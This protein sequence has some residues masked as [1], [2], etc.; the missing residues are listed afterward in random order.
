MGQRATTCRT[1]EEP[2][3]AAKRMVVALCVL[4]VL[5]ATAPV[6]ASIIQQGTK[7]VGTG[8]IGAAEQGY[9]VAVS[10]D[11]NTAV[12]GGRNDNGNV[13]AMWV[14][15]RSGGAWSQQGPKLVGTGA[16][17]TAR[18]GSSVAVSADGNTADVGGS[19]DAGGMGAVGVLTRS[20]GVW[21]QQGAK[22]VGTGGSGSNQG[23]S[24][25][26]SADGNTVVVGGWIDNAGVGAVWVFT[27][28]AGV[29]SQQG[30]KLVG[31]GAVGDAFQGVSVA[32]AAGGKTA[33]GGGRVG[34]GGVGA[35]GVVTSSAGVGD[36]QGEQ[37][38]G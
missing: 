6:R 32:V 13:G 5:C 2:L 23:V 34:G 11:G 3:M 28:V 18:Q 24:V 14:Y 7:L 12:V 9:S 33:V 30:A 10:A 36:Q 38:V 35:V 37:L 29:W 16:V 22:L 15:T 21:S 31:T 25:A 8:A 4:A 20:A 17:G 26:A 19:G 27:R 1:R